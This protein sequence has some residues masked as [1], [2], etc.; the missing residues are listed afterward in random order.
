MISTAG[1]EACH[2]DVVG[3]EIKTVVAMTNP[4]RLRPNVNV[5]RR[6]DGVRAEWD[7]APRESQ[8]SYRTWLSQSL[9]TGG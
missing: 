8:E 3:D 2:E 4:A 6:P 7:L 5:E 9:A 1:G